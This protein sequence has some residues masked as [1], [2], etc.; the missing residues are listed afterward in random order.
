MQEKVEEE[1]DKKLVAEVAVAMA[2]KNLMLFDWVDTDLVPDVRPFNDP[3]GATNIL[4]PNASPLDFFNLLFG[5]A[6]PLLVA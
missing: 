4:Q 5:F 3:A 2:G 6:W 1:Q